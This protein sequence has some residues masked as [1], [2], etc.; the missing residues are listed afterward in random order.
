MLPLKAFSSDG[1]GYLSNILRAVYY[2]VQSGTN[3]INM[4]FDMKSNSTE[5]SNP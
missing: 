3:V 5:F 1:T 4:S 2:G